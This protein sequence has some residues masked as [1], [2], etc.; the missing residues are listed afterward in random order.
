VVEA[1]AK[2]NLFLRVLGRREDGYHEVETLIVPVTLA[3]RLEVRDTSPPR[4]GAAPVTLEVV[5]DPEAVRGVPGDESNLVVRAALALASAVGARRSAHVRLEKRVPVGAGLGGGSADAA[6]VIRALDEV[7]GLGLGEETLLRVAASVG[8]DVPALLAGGGVLATGRGERVSRVPVLPLDLALV[9]FPF[10]V[11]A[12]DAYRWWDEEGTTGP[13]PAP[14]LRALHPGGAG[15]LGLRGLG[16]LLRN[17][18]EGPVAARHPEVAEAREVLLSGGAVAALMSGSGPTVV[19]VLPPGG[20]LAPRAEG[21]VRRLAGRP[22]RYVRTLPGSPA[23]RADLGPGVRPLGG[24][25]L[26]GVAAAR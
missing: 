5:G 24:P 2:V 6:A 25:G 10:A 8:S 22:V 14:A 20:R 1:P 7:W 16:G 12:A 23:A 26:L 21:R 3:D 4:P 19:G 17:D 13:D 15:P 11:R 9:T 18:L